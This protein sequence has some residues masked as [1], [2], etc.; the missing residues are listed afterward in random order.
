MSTVDDFNAALAQLVQAAA[1]LANHNVSIAVDTIV[2]PANA[3][4]APGI[5]VSAILA[6][7]D[8]AADRI[9]VNSLWAA[10][11]HIAAGKGRPEGRP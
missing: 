1:T 9:D 4:A 11:E 6:D 3:P 2:A 7:L 8:K 10:K 5:D